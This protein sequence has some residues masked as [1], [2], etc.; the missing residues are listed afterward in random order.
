MRR[1]AYLIVPAVFALMAFVHLREV[2]DMTVEQYLNQTTEL[3]QLA[4]TY[5]RDRFATAMTVF[6]NE[7]AN[8]P[9]IKHLI[10]QGSQ[11][12]GDS[13]DL[14]RTELYAGLS[15]SYERL[16]EVGLAEWQFHTADGYSFLRFD[17]PDKHD[18]F[19]LPY[20]PSL[21]GIAAREQPFD[22]FEVG[23]LFIGFRHIQP[24]FLDGRLVGS[25]EVGVSFD[26]VRDVLQEIS[27]D[28]VYQFL[29][30][31]NPVEN[32]TLNQYRQQH[33][34]SQSQLLPR[35]LVLNGEERQASPLAAIPE[36]ELDRALAGRADLRAELKHEQAFSLSLA[37]G[38]EQY[39]ASFVPV[40]DVD[41]Q[42]AA[43]LVSYTE[44]P[45]LTQIHDDY[46]HDFTVALLVIAVVSVLLS[47]LAVQ[48]TRL[49][50]QQ[51]RTDAISAAVGEGIFVLGPKGESVFVN[52][53]A[54][55][56]TGYSMDELLN[57]DIH[58]LIHAH[59]HDHDDSSCPI[60]GTLKTG[61]PYEGDELFRHRN[62]SMLPVVVT[63]R[64]MFQEGKI[65]GVVTVFR[66]ITERKK[67]EER[68]ARMAS[69]DELT[70][71]LN[72]RALVGAI[73]NE[74]ARIHRSSRKS[75]LIMIDFDHFKQV[76][77]NYG[78]EAG[79]K[80]LQHVVELAR[81][82]LRESDL[83]GRLGGEE[84]A[85]LLPDT[86]L[87]GAKVLAERMRQTVADATT[88]SRNGEDIRMTLSIGVCEM[89]GEEREVSELLRR[90]DGALYAA[91]HRG[92]NRVETA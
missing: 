84:F 81:E 79:D 42:L 49:R 78:H 27:P 51:Q 34:L 33:H 29:L 14:L 60:L 76:N 63:S 77:D 80:V 57:S 46:A 83:L 62:G 37:L 53:S 68:L 15:S 41:Q 47:V 86:S 10:D 40:L 70:G 17:A 87:E 90:V 91:K 38:G 74:I 55:E 52:S 45:L 3:N 36:A 92:R 61:I 5:S 64:P 1:L 12:V 4:L 71:V 16:R 8:N 32:V 58:A 48:H 39:T 89:Q 73:S 88:R 24:L 75:A 50:Q 23:R 7:A 59:S 25:T 20:R 31:S 72:R 6:L 67:M 9:E 22:V 2:R 26:Q 65:T 66:D 18:D 43:Y 11:S 44:A 28:T 85:A 21:R 30:R 13:R 54:A 35:Y 69:I 82:C 19:L 56:L